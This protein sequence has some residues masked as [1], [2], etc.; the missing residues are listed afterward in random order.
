M[1]RLP[2]ETEHCLVEKWLLGTVARVTTHVVAGCHGHTT[3]LS[4]CPGSILGV[5]VYYSKWHYLPSHQLWGRCVTVNKRLLGSFPLQSSFLVCST[6]ANGGVDGWVSRAVH[7]MGTAIPNVP[8]SGAFIWFEK[9]QEPL[10][11][12][13]PDPGWRP[14][15]QLAV[16]VHFLRCGSLLVC[17][18]TGLSRCPEPGLRLNDISRI[19][20]SQYLLP[21]QSE[22]PN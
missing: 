10:V 9:T 6:T 15:K 21:T 2:C 5:T 13:L 18:Q 1:T 8:Q 19:H 12:V 22:R 20:W 7:V 3:G 16:R 4:W 11:K 14:M 17:R